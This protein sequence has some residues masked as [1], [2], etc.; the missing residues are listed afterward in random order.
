[1]TEF[2]VQERV[3][4]KAVKERRSDYFRIVDH[5]PGIVLVASRQYP[6]GC[7]YRIPTC[8]RTLSINFLES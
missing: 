8:P 5:S 2:S 3:L 6:S 1:M 4:E 7:T